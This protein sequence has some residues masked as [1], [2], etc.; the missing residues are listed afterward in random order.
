MLISLIFAAGSR[1]AAFSPNAAI[2]DLI[3][4]AWG[5][6][7]LFFP[8]LRPSPT[9]PLPT[10]E[11]PLAGTISLTSFA[12]T[13][14]QNFD[15]LASSGDTNTSVP[16]GWAFSEAGT[17]A[18][19]TYRARAGTV[20]TGDTYSW[21]QDLSSDRAFGG[22]LSGTLIPTVGA[23]FTNNTGAVMASLTL[24]YIGEQWRL[25]DGP[26]SAD[27]LDFQYSTDATSL[28]TGTW[29]NY[30]ALDFSSPIYDTSPA[31]SLDGNSAANR[32]AI[33]GTI[34][35][36][37]IANGG[38]IWI[39]WN[40]FNVSGADDAL[41]ID[42]L[43]AKANPINA[44]D[45]NVDLNSAT[46][47]GATAVTVTATASDAVVG[48][49][50]VNL[51][52]S[53]TN[54]TAGDYTL[55][56]TTITIP[57]GQTSGTVTFTIQDDATFEGP[58]TATLTISNP[59]SGISLGATT[60][61]TIDIADNDV[62]P[63]IS[64]GNVSAVE[65]I[66]DI[67]FTV[68]Q[69]AVSDLAT[70]FNYSTADITATAG[71]DYTAVSGTATIL[72]GAITT[73]I[74]VPI[75]PDGITEADE[76]FRLT[77]DTPVNAS[78]ASGTALATIIDDET[79]YVDNTNALCSN[80]GPGVTRELPFCTITK[81]ATVAA[82]GNTV[83]VLAGMY[84]ETVYPNSGTA[85]QPVTFHADAGV[86]VTGDPGGFGSAFA[87]GAKSYIVIDGFS[88]TNT[89][90]KG[91]YAD[92]SDHLTIINNHV[93]NAGVTSPTHPYEQGIYLRGTTY[94]EISGNTTDHNT[95][96]GIRLVL[97]SDHNLV[98]NNISFANF[99]V[100]ETD[101]A[102]IE[103]TGSSYN[104]VIHNVVYSNED[105][106]INVY[107]HDL[108]VASSHNLIAGNLSYENGDH[109]I[110]TN[111]S[112]YNTVIGNT[113]HGNGTVGINFEGEPATGSHHAVIRN[114]ISSRNGYTPPTGSFG[115]NLRVDTASVDGTVS[116][117]NVFDI[118]NA[119][120]QIIWNNVNYVS[121][122]ALQAAFPA[123]E[124]NG[125]EGDPLFADPVPSV[126]RQDGVPYLG[127]AAVGD[128]HVLSGS[129]AIDS[130]DSDATGEPA[131][132][133]DGKPRIDD[134][135]AANTGVGTR[136]YDDRG[137]FEYQPPPSIEKAFGTPDLDLGAATSLTITVTNPHSSEA[138]T[139][140]GFTDTMPAGLTVSDQ[141]SS[142]CGGTLN[143]ASNVLTLTGASIAGGG[144]CVIGVTVTGE[145]TGVKNNVTSR[146]TS[147]NFGIGNTA[148]A[149]VSVYDNRP[150]AAFN[151]MP[152]P[153]AC[154][155]P[156]AF[157][158]TASTHGHPGRTITSYSWDFGDGQTGSGATPTHAYS[159]YAVRTASLTVTDDNT[160][161]RTDTVSHDVMVSLGN[162]NPVAVPG[163]P[164][165][166]GYLAPVTF[167][168]RGS[169]DPNESC[170]DRIVRYE[171]LLNSTSPL[172]EGP[173]LVP[174]LSA[175][176]MG[177]T[178]TI[179]LRVTDTFGA[180]GTATTTLYIP[181]PPSAGIYADTET[182]L[183]ANLNVTPTVAL[184][185]AT[186]ATATTDTNFKGTLAA[187]PVTGVVRVTNASP[188]GSYIVTVKAF[189][190]SGTAA[191]TF[192][193]TVTNGTACNGNIGFTSPASP[194]K[195]VGNTPVSIAVG[196]FNGDGIQDMVTVNVNSNNVSVLIGDGSGGFAAAVNYGVASLP[197][198]VAV[199]D[200][201]GD[202]KQDLV[203]A[204]IG[205]YNISVL[206]GDGAGGFSA[207]SNYGLGTTPVSVAIGDLNG[208]GKP[209][210]AVADP[211]VN[212]VSIL[213]G[214]GSG[215]FSA[216]ANFSVGS[217]PFSVVI[218]DLNGDG[219]PD[220]VTVNSASNNVSVLLGN[221]SGGFGAAANFGV[222][223]NPYS[224]A[225]GDLNGDGLQDIVTAN[226]ASDNVSVL[227]GNGSGGF[228]AAVN[229]AVGS[230]PI[231]LVLGDLNGDGKPDIATANEITNTISVLTGTGTGSFGAPVNF[232]VGSDP[233]SVTFGDLNADG[234]L[235]V[236][237]ANRASND[238]SIR[239]AVCTPVVDLSVSAN[240]ASAS[241]A[242]AT[243]VTVTATV[244]D[245]VTG[246]QT[247][248]LEV[249]GSNI[250]VADYTLTGTTITIP[251]GETTGSV[252]F[253]VVNDLIYEGTETAIMTISNP[254]I[255]IALGTT[256]TQNVVITD[257][258]QQ[259]YTITAS[260][261]PAGS[262]TPSGEVTVN[263]NS[264]QIFSINP[265]AYH[266]VAS[267]L[268]DGVPYEGP[269][270][271]GTYTFTNVVSNHTIAVTFAIDTYTLTY[272]SGGNGSITGA[273]LQTVNHGADGST[274]TAVPATGYHFVDWSDN[275]TQNPRTDSGI[276][277]DI[278]VTANFTRNEYTLTT[279]VVGYGVVNRSVAGPYYYGDAVTLT[280]VPGSTHWAFSGFGGDLTGT[281]NPQDIAINDNKSV[282][283]TFAL[284]PEGY[285]SD[286]TPR[287]TGDNVIDVTDFTMIG[288][289]VVGLETPD[290]LYN[291]FQRADSAPRATKGDGLLTAGDYVQAGRYAAGLDMWS[292]AGG[293]TLASLFPFQEM[294]KGQDDSQQTLQP[295]ILRV[296]D[297][298][299]S[300]DSTV[301]VSISIDAQGDEN[302][303]GFTISYDGTILSNPVVLTGA[304]MPGTPPIVNSL[305]AG[306]VG[307]VTAMTTGT[308][309]PFG[310]REI[311]KIRFNILPTASGGPTS[312]AF[313]GAPPVVNQVSSAA[314][315][316]LPTTF[317]AG[318]VTI[319][320]PT[321][322][323]TSVGGIVLS[324][325]GQAV[326]NARLS[327]TDQSGMVR[328]AISNSFGF[329]RFDDVT[330]GET[331]VLN[332]RSKSYVFAPQ[333][334]N[335]T[336]EVTNL[337]VVAEP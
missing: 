71:L 8:S 324:P 47:T 239:L 322:A 317:N 219:K 289:F 212:S 253:K 5:E 7:K 153:A 27:R 315:E 83:Y 217:A 319:L 67:S 273:S 108:G 290:P 61:Q 117:Y 79:F 223:S 29:T 211:W 40:D 240:A 332:V 208:D 38:T 262:I 237:T 294:T 251:D 64:V 216:P 210:L 102:G 51:G 267:V 231:S 164:Y 266:H 329:F 118:G 137:A 280:A 330:V 110:D 75:L 278:S 318:T 258:L 80:S 114:N 107:V 158:A 3:A 28:T 43:A 37:N 233:Y 126:L 202:G 228:S 320:A 312:L 66:G 149:T 46:E 170:G 54:I 285:E 105:S 20:T 70:T 326:R 35:G 333:L 138:L 134:P 184:Q 33:S 144:S 99:S 225:A 274:V 232:A 328:T 178:H 201:N 325:G 316:A 15:T 23:S 140:V 296:E 245:P 213:L 93:S 97:N 19:S 65:S 220:I 87:M 275:S 167:D 182:Q 272:M 299:A 236:A 248:D 59:T 101:A 68:T 288:R 199:G 331:Y 176:A 235:D 198:E 166:G 91:I 241:E 257:S 95:C 123:Q 186:R 226:S 207:A 265:D 277:A 36:L 42:D 177:A 14:T 18:N 268:I 24:S 86:T 308:T 139:G 17:N 124:L 16:E 142:Q 279:T 131:F 143:V 120:V 286:V 6:Q 314:A 298:S 204:N 227:L 269:L 113:A 264:G 130:A 4:A 69:S 292:G 282:T 205:S 10:G 215:G 89:P 141:T 250:T 214:D 221:G 181:Y 34:S 152:N 30:D 309:I 196:D 195:P 112:P 111:N 244:S 249:S 270:P 122:A 224:V 263:T 119:S 246:A 125:L 135:I 155:Q 336:D 229:F 301:T 159:A 303:F 307:V 109:G 104:T 243:V 173:T 172:G 238:V 191:K 295:R 81:A 185:N 92:A 261:G 163:G 160:P 57:N 9:A 304:D 77:I 242:A 174:D 2:H 128:Y 209:D 260:A 168:G 179:M 45:L 281:T 276:T 39:R 146:V 150:H 203:T 283:A 53:G 73:T 218:G 291:E 335:V 74:P 161:P 151:A 287:P 311:V 197:K 222:G 50:S 21:G 165:S 193:L 49:Q 321:A 252:T 133:L 148:S 175:L 189:G 334:L 200:L 72:P 259:N 156:V 56:D 11:R 52:V 13:Y 76:T 44:V 256:L 187:D 78:I 157:D 323:G 32:S 22:L 230:G 271:G 154:G 284:I 136:T 1:V 132:D 162:G 169:Y 26:R 127:T 297:V 84:A 100:V 188:A 63:S 129:P 41:G 305:T 147:A 85:G 192:T 313:T 247:V 300:R 190:P 171:W 194:E 62:M 145:T 55:S 327:M 58:E 116:D 98:S 60:T 12:S 25:G 306:K 180:V 310:T 293:E 94:S 302:G 82:A 115:G 337:I 234:K 88:I 90:Y 31:A 48:Q 106:G 254:S 183:G 96:I 103:L 121:L 206:L 255:G